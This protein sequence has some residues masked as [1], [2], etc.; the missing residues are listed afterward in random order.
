MRHQFSKIPKDLSPEEYRQKADRYRMLS[1]KIEGFE[2]AIEKK[3]YSLLAQK[4]EQLATQKEQAQHPVRAPSAVELIQDTDEAPRH[5]VDMKGMCKIISGCVLVLI[6]IF[7]LT[8]YPLNYIL[9]S[10]VN[11]IIAAIFILL[12]LVHIFKKKCC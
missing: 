7:F 10:Q 1:K 3:K 8:R 12:G 6:G 4:C 9:T 2:S 5:H 11:Y